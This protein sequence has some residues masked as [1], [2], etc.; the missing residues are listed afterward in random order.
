MRPFT[1]G[2]GSCETRRA[3]LG[4]MGVVTVEDRPLAGVQA[5]RRLQAA[6]AEGT[7]RRGSSPRPR[8]YADTRSLKSWVP[9]SFATPRR[10][11]TKTRTNDG[12]FHGRGS[13]GEGALC[14]GDRHAL[15]VLQATRPPKRARYGLGHA[16]SALPCSQVLPAAANLRSSTRCCKRPPLTDAAVRTTAFKAAAFDRSATPPGAQSRS[17]DPPRRVLARGVPG[18]L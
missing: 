5:E 16:S 17:L 9:R 11:L 10:F 4:L 12:G 1:R 7:S 15:E 2:P 6:S 13:V 8:R 3:M 14:E 18:R